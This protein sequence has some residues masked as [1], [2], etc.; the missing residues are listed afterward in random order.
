MRASSPGAFKRT[1]TVTR[2]SYAWLESVF[3]VREHAD[4]LEPVVEHDD[5]GRGAGLDRSQVRPASDPCRHLAGRP[6]CSCERRPERYEVPDGLDHRDRATG[7]NAVRSA[8]DAV[9][10]LEVDPGKPVAP[11][12]GTGC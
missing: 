10:D 11:V 12:T 8:R 7:E 9:L 1:P 4:N 6:Q 3:A 2:R 5:V